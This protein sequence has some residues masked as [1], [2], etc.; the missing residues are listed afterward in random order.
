MK[1]FCPTCGQIV[2]H[3]RLGVYLSPRQ[4]EI[5]DMVKGHR[6]IRAIEIAQRLGITDDNVRSHVYHT[7][8]GLKESGWRIVSDH[9]GYYL[10]TRPPSRL[11]KI[12]P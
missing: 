12:A 3:K 1:E 9:D 5:V 7:N 6:G 10:T 11:A 2:R 8:Q 4:A